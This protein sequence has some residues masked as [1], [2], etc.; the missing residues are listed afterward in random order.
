MTAENLQDPISTPLT[1]HLSP[2]QRA[3]LN[4]VVSAYRSE[5]AQESGSKP[6]WHPEGV[7]LVFAGDTTGQLQYLVSTDAR[8]G[9]NAEVQMAL[10]HVQ[11]SASTE[12]MVHFLAATVTE[13]SGQAEVV[14]VQVLDLAEIFGRLIEV[15]YRY[16]NTGCRSVCPLSGEEFKPYIGEAAFL[17]GTWTPVCEEI[18]PPPGQMKE[19]AA[20][21]RWTVG[22]VQAFMVSQWRAALAARQK[23]I[24]TS[25]AFAEVDRPF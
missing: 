22:E 5:R 21:A 16:N 3:I 11:E 25:P 23:A 10:R 13:T 15:E 18:L 9:A 20:C 4:Q 14:S 19:D 12:P 7:K 1:A 8:L 6:G 17:P 24:P 2:V